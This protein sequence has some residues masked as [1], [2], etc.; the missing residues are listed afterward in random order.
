GIDFA[1][2]GEKHFYAAQEVLD[3]LNLLGAIAD[4]TNELAVVGVLRSPLGAIRDRDLLHLRDA[5]ALCPFDAERVP[6]GLPD[7]R[8]LYKAKGLEFPVVVV[9]DLH[10]G[11]GDA[12]E[13]PILREWLTGM[14][15][16]RCGRL[17]NRDRVAA[18]ERY[19]RIRKEET[20]RLLYVALTRAKDRL[21]LT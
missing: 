7:V 20:R 4:P 3:L 2:E 18:E 13:G 5:D 17:R 6:R 19:R 15:G 16:F 11:P 9:P 8:R 10:R 14:V 1:I 12:A 21:L